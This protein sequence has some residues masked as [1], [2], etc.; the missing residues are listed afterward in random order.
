MLI[1]IAVLAMVQ[2]LAGP[3]LPISLFVNL[4]DLMKLK[5]DL[6][7][8]A[9]LMVSTLL[10]LP[11]RLSQFIKALIDRS[12]RGAQSVIGLVGMTSMGGSLLSIYAATWLDEKT[13]IRQNIVLGYAVFAATQVVTLLLTCLQGF[14]GWWIGAAVVGTVFLVVGRATF[15]GMIHRYQVLL[16]MFMVICAALLIAKSPHPEIFNK[17]I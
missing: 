15:K 5:V 8:A 6:I 3:L 10:R 9:L 4:A 13:V 17:S 12:E 16:S 11:P 7:V 2:F 1:V 14:D